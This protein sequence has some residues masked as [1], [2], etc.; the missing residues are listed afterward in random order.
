MGAAF[1]SL[2]DRLVA[3]LESA[4]GAL[5]A[6]QS[7][8]GLRVLGEAFG[9]LGALY[10]TLDSGAHPELSDY[11]Q[12]VYDRCLQSI[13]EAGPGRSEGLA[14]PIVLLRQIR[15]AERGARDRTVGRSQSPLPA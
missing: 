6:G 2:L 10:A 14:V 9:L 1:P 3:A 12:S 13:G 11:L 4:H 8:E 7:K 5:G 15:T